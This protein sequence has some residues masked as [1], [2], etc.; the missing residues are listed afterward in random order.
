MLYHLSALAI[1]SLV[2]GLAAVRRISIYSPLVM[3]SAVW[4]SVFVAGIAFNDR[5]YP[6]KDDAFIAWIIWFLITSLIYFLI[7]PTGVDLKDKFITRKLPF[8]Y[9]P[10]LGLLIVWLVYRIWIVGSNGSEHFFLNLRLSSI[11]LDGFEPL[12]LVG[13]FYPLVFALFLFEHVYARRDNRRLRVLCWIWM[14]AYALATMG[15]FAVLTPILSWAVIQ[16]LQGKL[17]VKKLIGLGGAT[18]CLML[19]AHFVRSGSEDNSTI[20][21]VLATYI[22]SPVVA[23]GYMDLEANSDWGAY[24]FRFVYAVGHSLGFAPEPAE[25]ILPYVSVPSLTNVYTVMHPFYF[26]FGPIGLVLGAIYY[27]FFFGVLFLLAFK[28][29]GIFLAIFSAYSIALLGQ[30]V[31]DLFLT[32]FS[33]NLQVFLALV[34]VFFASRRERYVC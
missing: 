3:G 24:V 17:P 2:L 15:K 22:Y 21:D 33:G 16:G 23:L 12:G 32:G 20:F 7:T 11:G 25:V 30:F 8:D 14:L 28:F 13:R 9:S 26:D 31:G 6:L 4:F 34:L 29:K 19:V 10:L 27:A 5:F 18:F 1:I